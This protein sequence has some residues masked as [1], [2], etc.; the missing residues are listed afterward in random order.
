MAFEYSSTALGGFRNEGAAH[1]KRFQFHS[2]SQRAAAQDV[3]IGRQVKD[4][5][6]LGAAPK[7]GGE[8][9]CFFSGELTT[10]LDIDGSRDYGDF[11]REVYPLSRT[12][13]LL[14]LHKRTI[15][16][17]FMR[18]LRKERTMAWKSLLHLLTVLGRCVSFCSFLLFRQRRVHVA[19]STFCTGTC[20]KNCMKTLGLF[21]LS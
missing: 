9:A 6:E 4:S 8:H 21:F 5:H 2:V 17:A 10:L 7:A 12:M 13:P 11:A 18:H 14:L 15:V 1:A 19:F 3:A 16:D 20:A